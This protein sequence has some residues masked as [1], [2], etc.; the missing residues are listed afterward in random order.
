MPQAET[1]FSLG[2]GY[3]GMRG[4]NVPDGKV[5]KLYVDDEPLFLRRQPESYQALC[6]K[7]GHGESAAEQWKRAA[8]YMHIPYDGEW[9]STCR[10]AGSWSERSGISRIP[11]LSITRCCSTTTHSRSTVTR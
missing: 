11:P 5:M 8:D 10:I 4:N 7:T 3:L 9:E 6:H 2:N 1:I